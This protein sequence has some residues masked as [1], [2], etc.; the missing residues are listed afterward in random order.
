MRP[1]LLAVTA[2]LA[3]G[4][5]AP[6]Q[7]APQTNGG[8]YKKMPW[9]LVDLWWDLGAAEPFESYSV[10]IT[11]DADVPED[12]SLYVAPVGIAELSGIKFYGGVQT[13]SDGYTKAD[14]KLR[15]IGR[16]LIFSMWGQRSPD[17]IRPSE[18]GYFQSS[19]HE[20]DFVSVRRPYHWTRGTYTYRLVKM[21][22]E[23]VGGKPHTWVGAFVYSKERDEN[24]FIGALRFAADRLVL[25]AKTA[26]FVEVYGRERPI[27]EIPKLT[28]TFGTPRVNGQIKPAGVKA[29]YPKGVPDYAEA[30]PVD[31]G[32]SV[33]VGVEAND[34]QS[35]TVDLKQP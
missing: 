26:S 34:R 31:D 21:D 9:H 20:G 24:V 8:K 11:L 22:Q 14:P 27:S 23:I 3:L 2:T 13:R 32:V 30:K 18:G 16:G 29:V 5:I 1:W 15:V 17:A 12:V 4:G 6:A 7:E 35:R 10:D 33:T 28:V 25:A 19:G